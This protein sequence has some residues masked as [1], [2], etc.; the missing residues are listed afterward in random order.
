MT[1]EP[2]RRAVLQTT[3]RRDVL[4]AAGMAATT[5]GV[6]AGTAAAGRRFDK[7]A[8]DGDPDAYSATRVFVYEGLY[9]DGSY[10]DAAYNYVL[11]SVKNAYE[12][13]TND[14]YPAG[15]KVVKYLT[16]FDPI[17][18]DPII[19]QFNSWRS[20]NGYTERGV[21]L[22]VHG[23]PESEVNQ[24]ASDGAPAFRTDS[25]AHDPTFDNTRNMEAFEATASHEP[26]HSWVSSSCSYVQ[27]MMAPSQDGNGYSEHS[28][29]TV[30]EDQYGIRY[31]TP[32]VGRNYSVENG[33]CW[34]SGGVA[35]NETPIYSA[36]SKDALRYSADHQ[37][38]LH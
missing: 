7:S 19:D 36:C 34:D 14:G 28:L 38:G 20:N 18:S 9:A 26:L 33:E 6:T 24:G 15:Y 1:D 30:K 31:N 13:G 11:D 29:G 35:S 10:S 8:S 3:N 37:H 22:L 4:R 21:H 16:G 2:N 17:C 25:G 32:F 27:D 23:C 5:V 12:D